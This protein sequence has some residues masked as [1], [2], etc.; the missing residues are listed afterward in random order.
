[1]EYQQRF[2]K[3][4]DEDVKMGVILALAPPQVQNHCLFNSHIL[5]SYAQVRTMLFD[6]CRAQADTAAGDVVPM[7]LSMLAKCKGK[8]GKGDKKG[9]RQRQRQEKREQQR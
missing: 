1:M 2:S 6:Y 9:Q 5:K 3:K 7:D 4:L 8:K